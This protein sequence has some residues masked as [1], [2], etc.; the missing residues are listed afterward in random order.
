MTSLSRAPRD[1]AAT[2]G[3]RA[4][5][6]VE[7]GEAEATA[8]RAAEQARLDEIAARE[9]AER[10]AELRIEQARRTPSAKLA[11]AS[12]RPRRR[13]VR[14]SRRRSSRSG[15]R[16]R[17]SCGAPRSRSAGRRG[18]WSS[19]HS[20]WSA[21]I[22]FGALAIDRMH[23]ADTAQAGKACR[24][25]RE[26]VARGRRRAVAVASSTRCRRTSMRSTPRSVRPS[27]LW[28]HATNQIEL[29]HAQQLL[30]EAN[31]QAADARAAPAGDAR[32][33]AD[34]IIRTLGD[35][36]HE[37]LRANVLCKR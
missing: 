13:S 35:R 31:R 3:R 25:C 18:W 36:R 9:R 37:V 15:S 5:G 19:P 23:E 32:H 8:R 20:R 10:E 26:G 29:K 34:Q 21:A 27:T 7:G 6:P 4:R 14:G 1:R 11:C 2:D 17:W 28:R 12:R 33:E 30:A 24:R 16:R 22:A